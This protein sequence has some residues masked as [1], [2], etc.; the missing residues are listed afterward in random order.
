MTTFSTS[1]Q[2]LPYSATTLKKVRSQ[3]SLDSES[4][5]MS[6]IDEI[7]ENDLGV[8]TKMQANL[9]KRPQSPTYRVS[10]LAKS[11]LEPSNTIN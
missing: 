1:M 7:Q 8:N 10:I 2:A 4:I 11:L 6:S 9:T 5:S 3:S